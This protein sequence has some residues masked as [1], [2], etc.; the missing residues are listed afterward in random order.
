[1]TVRRPV[2]VPR[3][4]AFLAARLR[5]RRREVV[6]WVTAVA[7]ALVTLTTVV[8]ALDRAQATADR[9]GPA[10]S[11]VVAAAPIGAGQALDAEAVTVAEW[12]A[13]LVPADAVT[14][15]TEG[16]VAVLPMG[17]G[18]VVVESRLAPGGVRGPAALLP[19]RT[20]A[21]AVPQVA[22][23]LALEPGDRVDVLAVVDP[24][25][26]GAGGDPSPDRPAA[27]VVAGGATV[28]A[29]ADGSTTVAVPLDRVAEVAAAL[30]QGVVTLALAS[31]LDGADGPAP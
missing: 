26:L 29:V 31:P 13:R 11:V 16:R 21:L 3:R 30:G 10:R 8:G 14:G 19:P 7:L 28:V 24:F 18:E 1:M 27:R 2:V 9:W 25:D 6:W 12:P 15:P 5:L 17:A 22:G 4:G 23:G 20:R